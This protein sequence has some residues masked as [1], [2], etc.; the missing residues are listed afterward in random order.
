MAISCANYDQLE[1]ASMRGSTLK[2][3]FESVE[4]NRVKLECV[5]ADLYVKNGKEFLLTKDG[6]EMGLDDLVSI[7]FV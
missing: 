6:K 7:D 3:Q 5:I 4:G 2:L 1:L